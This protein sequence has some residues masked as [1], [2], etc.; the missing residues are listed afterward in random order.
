MH[1]ILI[2]KKNALWIVLLLWR[3]AYCREWGVPKQPS[4]F[5]GICW[6]RRPGQ[7][8][9]VH[10]SE[11]IVA[12]ASQNNRWWCGWLTRTW[13]NNHQRSCRWPGRRGRSWRTDWACFS[14]VTG[15][16]TPKLKSIG[17]FFHLRQPTFMFCLH[18]TD[19]RSWSR[20]IDWASL[21]STSLSIGLRQPQCAAT[22]C[23]VGG[24][25]C[26][27]SL[28]LVYIFFHCQSSGDDIQQL[29]LL[30]FVPDNLICD[31]EAGELVTLRATDSENGNRQQ[32]YRGRRPQKCLG[33]EQVPTR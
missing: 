26:R 19:G 30:S 5:M 15:H 10:Q 8:A 7:Y 16:K 9:P 24:P 31:P 13:A 20:A 4:K 27:W 11:P 21:G 33:R 25:F 17:L 6:H 22:H 2:G 18:G 32:K 3:N 28:Q 23:R 29:T 12:L 14:T 1:K